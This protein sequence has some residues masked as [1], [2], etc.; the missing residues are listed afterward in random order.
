MKKI[1]TVLFDLDGVL[2]D[3]LPTMELAWESVR[4]NFNVESSFDDFSKY[5]GIPFREILKN[6]LIDQKYFKE[7]EEH[8]SYK[9]REYKNK[10]KL[11]NE[12]KNILNWLSKKNIST[13]IV[14]SKEMRRTYELV[15]MFNLK[16]SLIVTP[17]LTKRGKPYPDPIFYATNLLS[18][19]LDETLFIGDMISDMNSAKNAGCYFLF[20]TLGYEKAKNINYGGSITSLDQI[21]EFIV[22]L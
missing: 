10:I 3:S 18:Q 9:A 6:L 7:V 5:I 22:Y 1:K 13:G 8:Y 4:K 20:Y 16:I 12:A 14:T 17:E 11:N 2:I 15:E 21:K 19:K